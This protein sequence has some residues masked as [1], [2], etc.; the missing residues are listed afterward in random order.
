MTSTT[1]GQGG[2]VRL[3]QVR[4]G[5]TQAVLTDLDAWV[6]GCA[7]SPDGTLLATTSADRTAR[8]WRVPD[9]AQQAMLTGHTRAVHRYAFTPE[10][11]LLATASRNGTVRCGRYPTAQRTPC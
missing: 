10:G 8:L 9:G 5:A 7:F 11:T 2:K 6:R 1:A 3:W 4:S